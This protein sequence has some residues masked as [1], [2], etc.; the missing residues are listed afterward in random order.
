M[1]QDL[2]AQSVS[3]IYPIGMPFKRGD[4]LYRYSQAAQN[5]AA[6][7]RLLINSNFAPGVT[8]Q[9]NVDGYEGNLY[10]KASIG[11]R[12]VDIA[13]TTARAKN[14]Y[15]GGHLVIYGTTIF[16]QH[17][18]VS[19][20]AGDTAKVRCWLSEPLAVEDATVSMGITAYRS[21]Y[22]AAA[23]AAHAQVNFESFV[24]LNL[25]PVTS[26]YFF[27]MLT[28]GP[29]CVTP[30]G[31]TWPGSAAHLRDIYANEADGTIQPPTISDPSLGYQRIGYLL[32]VTGGTASNYGDLWIMLQLDKG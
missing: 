16:H 30:T 7:A 12:Y 13:D 3:Q 18:I 32:S 5:L 26:G 19:S 11:Q 20:E 25:I 21:I 9:K 2:F 23:H 29:V 17:Y 8:G 10:A 15:Q 22:S 1:R 28:A 27:W 14:F 4:K 31:V 24:G 6:L